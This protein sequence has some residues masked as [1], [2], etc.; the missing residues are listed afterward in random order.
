MEKE[1]FLWNNQ[2]SFFN[3]LQQWKNLNLTVLSMFSQYYW[4]SGYLSAQVSLVR[5]IVSPDI[6]SP[7]GFH[8]QQPSS[9]VSDCHHR[10]PP[11]SRSDSALRHTWFHPYLSSHPAFG[12]CQTQSLSVS[13]MD[14]KAKLT[15]RYWFLSHQIHLNQKKKVNSFSFRTQASTSSLIFS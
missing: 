8:L 14:P 1:Q 12:S 5:P 15:L 3:H 11:I 4:K 7:P 2:I 13:S 6:Q 10:P 9:C